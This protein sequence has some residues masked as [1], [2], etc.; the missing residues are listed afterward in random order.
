MPAELRAPADLIEK[1][2][3]GQCVAFV[4]SGFSAPVVGTWDALLRDLADDLDDDEGS[5]DDVE[6]D[7]DDDDEDSDDEGSDDEYEDDDDDDEGSS[8]VEDEGPDVEEGSD[9]SE[10]DLGCEEGTNPCGT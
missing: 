3:K 9:D 2:R 1:I 10:D 6:G 4:G 5:D 8:D 7:L